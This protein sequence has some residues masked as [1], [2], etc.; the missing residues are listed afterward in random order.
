MIDSGYRIVSYR[1][2][3]YRIPLYF[4]LSVSFS[5]NK[6]SALADAGFV[7]EAISKLLLTNHSGMAVR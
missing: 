6:K 3:S 2:V 7:E 4:M 5:T 1:I